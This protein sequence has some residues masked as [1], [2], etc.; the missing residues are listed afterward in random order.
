M[1]ADEF[2]IS[3][4]DNIPMEGE[5]FCQRYWIFARTDKRSTTG[6]TPIPACSRPVIPVSFGRSGTKR[7]ADSIGRKDMEF[8]I[9]IL[10]TDIWRIWKG[11]TYVISH[12]FFYLSLTGLLTNVTSSTRLTFPRLTLSTSSLNNS[13]TSIISSRNCL[14][15][16]LNYRFCQNVFYFYR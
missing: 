15:I 2:P 10:L 12:S 3:S 14:Y 1:L 8:F 5:K 11:Q 16:I 4:S 6:K 9:D 7:A 13:T